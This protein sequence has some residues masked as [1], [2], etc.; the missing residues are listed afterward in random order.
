M[1]PRPSRLRGINPPLADSYGPQ[2]RRGRAGV[3]CV[4]FP[5][6]LR[7]TQLDV[8]AMQLRTTPLSL[9]GC[10]T[11]AAKPKQASRNLTQEKTN[12]MI[13]Q[14]FFLT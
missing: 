4:C 3:S 2:F 9:P 12:I 1:N 10:L 11:Y 7:T 8:L 5:A 13:Q 6:N 14:P